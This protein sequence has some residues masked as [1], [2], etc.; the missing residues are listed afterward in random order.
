M[1][2]EL[3]RQETPSCQNKIFFNSAGSSLMPTVVV[4]KMKNYLEEES[5]EGGYRVAD[6]RATEFKEIYNEAAKLLHTNTHNIAI[7]S[8]ATDAFAKALSSVSFKD[9][10]VIL[11]TDDD[12]ISNQL[13]FLSIQK[14]FNTHIIR[15]INHENGDLDLDNFEKLIKIQK[16]KLVCLSHVPSNS[17]MVQP[18]EEVGVM[19]KKYN[20]IYVVDACQSFGQLDLNVGEIGCDFL[21]ATSRKF[22][23]GPRGTGLLYVSDRILE[24]GMEPLIVDMKG[25]EWINERQYR[26]L[27]SA[28]RFEFWEMSM[29]NLI[30]FKEALAYANK[31]GMTNIEKANHDVAQ[32]LRTK[33]SSIKGV[34]LLDKGT[35]QAS[36]VTWLKEGKD[37][38]TTENK[39]NQ[40]KIYYSTAMR[41]NAPIDFIKKE[42]D[43]CI[44][45][46]P[47]YFNTKEEVEF[48]AEVIQAL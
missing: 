17:G 48:A 4:E 47:H 42:T 40:E 31:I 5:S 41:S 14:R 2:I 34:R 46:S 12:Y 1:N 39:L 6:R 18:I 32:Y 24:A 43:W 25:A 10:D 21:S 20:I 44:R 11:T 38:K 7:T 13:A 28:Q 8:S 33:L 35:R 27:A 26:S 22:M 36:I 15:G 45:F 3:L 16:P 23:R 29:V 19:C 9:G 30:G 37:Q